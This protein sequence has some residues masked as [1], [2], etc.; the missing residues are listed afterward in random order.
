MYQNLFGRPASDA[1]KR[2]RLAVIFV[3]S[4]VVAFCVLRQPTA[5]NA[6]PPLDATAVMGSTIVANGAA[7]PNG[8]SGLPPARLPPPLDSAPTTATAAIPPP[9]PAGES[10]EEALPVAFFFHEATTGH[11][12]TA[13]LMNQSSE[14][15]EITV[16]AVS[17]KTHL[18]SV[19][20]VSAPPRR[21]KN[22]LLEG[23]QVEAGDQ[24]TLHSPPFADQNLL[25]Q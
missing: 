3:V 24:V 10:V 22:L 7:P 2:R 4:F 17:G 21:Y 12:A 13:N 8:D 9:V 1:A 14:R 18:R 6:G 5:T 15:L 19:V 23:L 11:A 25:A 16:T 20:E